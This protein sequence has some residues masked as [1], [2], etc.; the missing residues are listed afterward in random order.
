MEKMEFEQMG[1]KAL[2]QLR[3][4]VEDREPLITLIRELGS[5]HSDWIDQYK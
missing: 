2:D 1:D 4:I 5:C 3:G